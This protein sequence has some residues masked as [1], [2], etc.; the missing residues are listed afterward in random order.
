MKKYLLAICT[1][2]VITTSANQAFAKDDGMV[3][4][5]ISN[6]IVISSDFGLVS[7]YVFRSITQ[8]G[9]RSAI[10]GTIEA[11]HKNS[12]LYIGFWGSSINFKANTQEDIELDWYGGYR[13]EFK[14]VSADAGVIY[15]SYPGVVGSL[16]YD[17]YETYIDLSSSYKKLGFGSKI[18]YSPDYFAGSGNSYYYNAYLGYNYNKSISLN[19]SVGYQEI[20][21]EGTYGLPDYLDWLVG[22]E[23]K[24]TKKAS[25]NLSYTDN[26]IKDVDC[27]GSCG[28]KLIIGILIG[29]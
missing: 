3:E 17:F 15:Y 10:Q 13:K 14:N 23:Y 5:F 9:D 2:A 6:N 8:S 11:D 7:N 16:D 22:V 28:S 29:L 25:L 26:N 21:E 19:G 27:S 12:G 20:G 1:I 24:L 18:N 4:D